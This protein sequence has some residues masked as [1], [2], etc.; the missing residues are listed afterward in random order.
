MWITKYRIKNQMVSKHKSQNIHTSLQWNVQ[1]T[2]RYLIKRK[3][4]VEIWNLIIKI[5]IV[6]L[7]SILSSTHSSNFVSVGRS[8]GLHVMSATGLQLI[9]RPDKSPRPKRSHY[10][11]WEVAINVTLHSMNTW[12][13]YKPMRCAF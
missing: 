1:V 10:H 11:R 5:K 9:H 12:E 3:H 6:Y 13:S 8:L 2:M 4:W 7:F